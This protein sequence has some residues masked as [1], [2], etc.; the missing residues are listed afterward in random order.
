MAIDMTVPERGAQP[1]ELVL[2]VVSDT[3]DAGM[4][5]ADAGAVVPQLQPAMELARAAQA[6]DD[7]AG[8]DAH[9]RAVSV[10]AMATRVKLRAATAPDHPDEAA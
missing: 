4:A 8:L 3:L 1:R 2:E 10:A 9:L 6:R 5:L 7:L